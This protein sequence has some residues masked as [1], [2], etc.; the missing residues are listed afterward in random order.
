[1]V[2]VKRE[3]WGMEVEGSGGWWWHSQPERWRQRRPE[4]AAAAAAWAVIHRDN[5]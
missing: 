2:E 4:A 5:A 1:M 3:K